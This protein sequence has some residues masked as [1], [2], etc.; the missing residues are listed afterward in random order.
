MRYFVA[1]GPI[2][3]VGYRWNYSYYKMHPDR[4]TEATRFYSDGRIVNDII[5]K[6]NNYFIVHNCKEITKEEYESM[7][8]L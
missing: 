4:R 3:K 6:F 1:K 7:L 2:Y 5:K 8:E